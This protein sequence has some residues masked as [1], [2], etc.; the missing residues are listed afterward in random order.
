M[1]RKWVCG[2]KG[3]RDISE[4]SGR[5]EAAWARGPAAA[6]LTGAALTQGW[7]G[8]AFSSPDSKAEAPA[9][10][11]LF[12]SSVLSQG[13]RRNHFLP[14]LGGRLAISLLPS[15][16]RKG[17]ARRGLRVQPG[18]ERVRG[19]TES[20]RAPGGVGAAGELWWPP[21]T[22]RLHTRE[23]TEESAERELGRSR[24]VL[25][26]AARVQRGPSASLRAFAHTQVH[27]FLPR[28]LTPRFPATRG[29]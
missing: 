27:A 9:A 15:V 29:H 11:L 2:G 5:P 26:S 19:P 20:D 17:P 21:G 3:R 7:L 18:T 12:W 24:N 6:E 4:S 16:R 1:C 25:H 8:S 14:S 23:E 28:S 13:C 10:D 22:C